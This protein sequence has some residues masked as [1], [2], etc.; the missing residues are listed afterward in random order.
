M[1]NG[2]EYVTVIGRTGFQH[3]VRSMPKRPTNSVKDYGASACGKYFFKGGPYVTIQEATPPAG[4][5]A[6]CLDE[7]A[8]E[9]AKREVKASGEAQS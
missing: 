3:I 8:K 2:K 9:I 6:R 1:A 7:L 4:I 5:C